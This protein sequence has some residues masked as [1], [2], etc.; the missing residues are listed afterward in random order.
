MGLAVDRRRR[1]RVRPSMM[2]DT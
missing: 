2:T 1:C